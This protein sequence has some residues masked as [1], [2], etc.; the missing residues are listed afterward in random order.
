MPADR[1]EKCPGDAAGGGTPGE[2]K[3]IT[4]SV[5]VRR[6]EGKIQPPRD[7]ILCTIWPKPDH[8]SADRLRE[9]PDYVWRRMLASV[10]PAGFSEDQGHVE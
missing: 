10:C 3:V 9:D 2:D 7:P 1:Q 5:A 6:D 8:P 4:T